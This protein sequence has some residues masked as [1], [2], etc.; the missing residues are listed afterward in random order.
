MGGQQ[1][2]ARCLGAL[3]AHAAQPCSGLQPATCTTYPLVVINSTTSLLHLTILTNLRKHSSSAIRLYALPTKRTT[4]VAIPSHPLQSNS[5]LQ[6]TRYIVCHSPRSATASSTLFSSHHQHLAAAEPVP[7][8]FPAHESS[9][10]PLTIYTSYHGRR[11]G[12]QAQQ[13]REACASRG[14]CR[15][16][17]GLRIHQ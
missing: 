10:N 6:Q 8:P 17:G 5:A 11:L 16:K 4:P 15:W 14:S 13:Q 1:G 9:S 12:A 2:T 7:R 3:S